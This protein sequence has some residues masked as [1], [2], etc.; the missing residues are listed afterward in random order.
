VG[1]V[2]YGYRLDV[3]GVHLLEDANEQEVLRQVRELAASGFSQR[4]IVSELAGWGYLSRSGRPFQKTQVAR[5]LV[6]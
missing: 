2:P 5:M 6:A 4:S 3:D 1:S